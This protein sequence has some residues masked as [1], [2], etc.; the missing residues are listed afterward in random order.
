MVTEE[1]DVC[2]IGAGLLG[3]FNAMQLAKRGLRVTIIDDVNSRR[4]SSYKVGESLLVYSNEFLRSVGELD[5]AITNSLPKDG[6]WMAHGLEGQ[7]RFGDNVAEW[8]FQSKHSKRWLDAVINKKFARTMYFDAQ[9]V[10]PEIEEVLRCNVRTTAGI[11]FHE[12]GYVRDVAINADCGHT[13]QWVSRND[14]K[15]ATVHARWVFDCSGRTRFLAKRLGHDVPF[16]DEFATTAVWAQFSHCTDDVF[17]DVW[18]YRSPDGDAMRRD[19]H[20]VHLWGD[21]YWIWLIR[22][23]GDRISVGVTF[24]RRVVGQGANVKEMFWDVLGRY[25]LLS[26][27]KSENVLEFQTYRNVQ[28]LT[29]TYVSSQR[30]A[31]AGDAAS[32]IDAYYSQGISLSVAISWHAANIIERDI[33]EDHLDRDY[34]DRVNR[35]A[36]ADWRIMRSMV[37]HKYRPAIADGRF[38]ILDHLLDYLILGAALLGRF[39]MA[40]WLVDTGG[41]TAEESPHYR[42]LRA[43]MEQ[44]LFLCRSAPLRRMDPQRFADAF[45]RWHRK[46]ADRAEWRIA[47]NETQ[48]PIKAAM[49]SQ[50]PIPKFWRMPY[51]ARMQTRTLTPREVHEPAFMRLKGTENRPLAFALSGSTL[52][53][54]FGFCY[55]VD[56]ADTALR[57]LRHRLIRRQPEA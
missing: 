18:I 21:G 30:Y 29:D 33:V 32:I 54:V 49:R 3:M 51:V 28:Y 47:H 46:L 23:A 43:V 1:T 4:A 31:M 36:D 48:P 44:Q 11:V 34:V 12:S 13:I 2:I 9:I 53:G 17:D 22:L 39:R 19:R 41:C 27:L 56:V 52:L 15:T 5:D 8:A 45:E 26:F 20:T 57:R 42:R 25:P 16:N 35:C 6:I 24:D 38:F 7:T 55:A 14:E 10:R 37:K 40:R 50:A